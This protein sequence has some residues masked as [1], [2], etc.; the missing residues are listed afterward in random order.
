[1]TEKKKMT[2]SLAKYTVDNIM[3]LVPIKAQYSSTALRHI[4]YHYFWSHPINEA[5][6][7]EIHNLFKQGLRAPDIVHSKEEQ[8]AVAWLRWNGHI[9]WPNETENFNTDGYFDAGC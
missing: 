4:I 6:R 7:Q 9:Y 2:F 5:R 8:P 3:E 1:M